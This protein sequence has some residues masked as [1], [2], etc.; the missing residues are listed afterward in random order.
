M[1]TV[2]TSPIEAV[3]SA[4]IAREQNVNSHEG[5]YKDG[6]VTYYVT[7]CPGPNHQNGDQNPSLH[8]WEV[9]GEDGKA[10]VAFN[11]MSGHCHYSEILAA[12]HLTHS[13]VPSAPT[14]HANKKIITLHDVAA[15]TKL[16][17]QILFNLG[18][19]DG[20]ATYHRRDG[21][22]YRE[23]GVIIPYFQ[24]D[25][26][27]F[28][29]SKIR[30]HLEKPAYSNDARW[31]WTEG[32]SEPIAY[33]MQYL[34]RAVDEQYIVL[35]EGESDFVTLFTY[36]I[37]A[38][39][40][41]GTS[42]IRATL[43][44]NLFKDISTIY[45]IQEKTDEAG[46]NFPYD[47]QVRL[48]A[49]GYTGEILRV[50]LR[51]LTG[52][53]D[54]NDLYKRLY[55]E[56]LAQKNPRIFAEVFKNALS[57]AKPMDY[58]TGKQQID[59]CSFTA[60]DAGNG[61][62]LY[63]LYGQDYLWCGASGWFVY[64]GTHWALDEEGVSVRRQAVDTLRKRRHA[65][66]DAGMEA[67]IAC[68]KGDEKRVNG[69]VSRFKTLVAINIDAFDSN[70]DLLNC[71]NGVVDLRTGVV[72]PHD[73]KQRF[74]YC[75]PVEYVPSDCPEWI[76]YLQNTVGGGREVIDY[77]Q[78]ALG[79]SLTGHTREEILFYLFGPTRSGKGTLAETMMALLPTPLSKM[80]DFNSFTARREG[81]VSNFDLA[82]LKPSRMIFA[83]ESQKSQ[84]L[85]PAKIKQLTGGDHITCCFKHR[86][87]FSY[88]PQFKVWM[89]SNHPVNGDPEDDALWG[90]VRVIAFP[91]SFLGKEDKTKKARL[92][93]SDVLSGVLYWAVQG[94]IKWYALGAAGLST[95]QQVK[96][97]TNAHRADLDYVQQWL[98]ECTDDNDDEDS[99]VANED[100]IASYTEW[101]RN[102]N[103]QYPKGP[104]GLAQSLKAKGYEVSKPKWIDGKTKRG[105][106]GLHVYHNN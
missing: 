21:R 83:S 1:T 8:F 31:K 94:A 99:W 65:A 101:C 55:D 19:H 41:P 78:L 90:R 33:G 98:D 46:N 4:F 96:E 32:D 75:L 66:V 81:D 13:L 88:R 47:V 57:Q 92:K 82:P 64:T 2:A 85:N 14:K 26:T 63:A 80:V 7:N 68:T 40:I 49:T 39:G 91:N 28:E 24:T 61:D 43:D 6:K 105:V 20:I 70:P 45:V 60:D 23:R 36:G 5:T 100:V 84:A 11:C 76:D 42:T 29:R 54:P 102:N 74:T 50:P 59:L 44:G 10:T 52:A 16:D 9:I 35:V 30:L 103:V 97:T 53:K 51:T 104:K 93:E 79:Y 18:W 106:G 89:L 3:I 38:L 72:T 17:W 15:H 69:C 12:L 73:R 67:V 22:A 27:E 48:R 56:M 77:L 87:F 25:G 34:S 58:D 95:P 37:P 86:N 62:A 71:K